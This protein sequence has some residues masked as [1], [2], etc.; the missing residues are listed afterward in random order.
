MPLQGS[1]SM[2]LDVVAFF[3]FIYDWMNLVRDVSIGKNNQRWYFD[4]IGL[5]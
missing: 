4:V 5:V 1:V 3:R 2:V